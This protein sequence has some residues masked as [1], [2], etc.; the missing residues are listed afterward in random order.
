[1]LSE[2]Q[3]IKINFKTSMHIVTGFESSLFDFSSGPLT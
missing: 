2:R 1:M 3:D